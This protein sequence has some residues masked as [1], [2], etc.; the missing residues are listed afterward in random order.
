VCIFDEGVFSQPLVVRHF[1]RQLYN[2][3]NF[4]I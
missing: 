3:T 2:F 1:L 4:K